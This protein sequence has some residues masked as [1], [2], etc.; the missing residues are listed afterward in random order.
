[1]FNF[2]RIET[3]LLEELSVFFGAKRLIYTYFPE[4]LTTSENWLYMNLFDF[5]INYAAKNEEDEDLIEEFRV[6]FKE[7]TNN[8]DE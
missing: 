4:K 3:S 7:T 2:Y 5:E 1:M 8:Q 6:K